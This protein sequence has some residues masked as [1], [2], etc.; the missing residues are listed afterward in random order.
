MIVRAGEVLDFYGG[1]IDIVA[2]ASYPGQ[3]PT[4]T[5]ECGQVG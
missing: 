2:L 4:P 1:S 3:T 5:V